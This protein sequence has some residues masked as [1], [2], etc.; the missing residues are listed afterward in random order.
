MA[1]DVSKLMVVEQKLEKY[2]HNAWQHSLKHVTNHVLNKLCEWCHIKWK[3]KAQQGENI[4]RRK[5]G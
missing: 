4:S 2:K 5:D 3:Y 1:E